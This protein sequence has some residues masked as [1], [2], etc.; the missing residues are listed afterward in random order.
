MKQGLGDEQKIEK[1][2]KNT[3]HHFPKEKSNNDKNNNN[4]CMHSVSD[5]LIFHFDKIESVLMCTSCDNLFGRGGHH[6]LKAVS[7]SFCF[8]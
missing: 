2:E 5:A 3:P 4:I 8:M 1:K 7:K 6:L